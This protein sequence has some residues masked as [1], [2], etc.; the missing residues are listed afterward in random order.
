MVHV[1]LSPSDHTAL[2]NEEVSSVGIK[3]L[4]G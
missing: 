3:I 2:N 4:G 1:F